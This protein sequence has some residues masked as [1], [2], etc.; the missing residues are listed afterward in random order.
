M[1]RLHPQLRPLDF[2]VAGY[3]AIGE[4]AAADTALGEGIVRD[5]EPIPEG[6]ENDNCYAWYW[7]L[8]GTHLDESRDRIESA[9]AASG[10]RSDFLDTR[11]M[12]YLAR[13][14]L[15]SAADSARRAA[16]LNPDDA[17]MLWQAE[18]LSEMSAR[19]R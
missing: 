10:E 17:Y 16:R 6:P 14:D 9:L 7:A 8:R 15:A 13:G 5:C 2:L 12:V 3:H 4:D 18:R 11:A 1:D 19:P